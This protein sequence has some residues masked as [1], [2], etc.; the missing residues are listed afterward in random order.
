M[1]VVRTRFLFIFISAKTANAEDS[2]RSTTAVATPLDYLSL[3]MSSLGQPDNYEAIEP[4][5]PDN[6][7]LAPAYP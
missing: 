1:K 3:R 4:T 5:T 6:D 2:S 7:Y